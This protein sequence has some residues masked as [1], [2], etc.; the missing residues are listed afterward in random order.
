MVERM[1]CMI[2]EWAPENRLSMVASDDSTD[3]L[4][5]TTSFKIDVDS[6]ICSFLPSRV[7]A[8]F[9]RGT[10]SSINRMTPRSAARRSKAFMMIFSSN[11]SRLTSS[12]M[13]RPSSC[14]RRSFS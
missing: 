4:F 3:A 7:L 14:A 11:S 9:G 13:E 6:T 8:I 10:P 5:C 2:T 1:P 12:P